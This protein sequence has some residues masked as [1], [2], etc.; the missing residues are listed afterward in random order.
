MMDVNSMETWRLHAYA[1]QELDGRERA[2]VES[3]LAGNPEARQLLED[4]MRQ[5][6]AM[7]SAYDAILDEPVPPHLLRAVSRQEPRR[8]WPFAAMAAGLAMLMVG[9]AGG[10]LGRDFVLARNDLANR[11]LGAYQVF[12]D[13]ADRPVEMAAADKDQLQGW[14]T[15]RIG[16]RFSVPDLSDKGLT[17]VGGRLLAEGQ[18]PAGLLIYEDNAKQRLS[19]YVAAN[20]TGRRADFAMRQV[21]PLMVCSWVEEDL[22]YALVGHQSEEA[23]LPL[24]KLAHD[25]FEA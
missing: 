17:L 12:A 22:V 9:G 19:I 13:D 1:D 11:A 4:I 3:H 5:K 15:G 7:K 14:L 25:R 18:V 10:W 16:R 24:A 6:R 21:G 2:E 20:T 8:M 23:M